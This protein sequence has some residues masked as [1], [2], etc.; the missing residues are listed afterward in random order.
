MK[1]TTVRGSVEFASGS[2]SGDPYLVAFINSYVESGI[3]TGCNYWGAV[4][5]GLGSDWQAYMTI[6]GAL[7]GLTGQEPVVEGVPENPDGYQ[8]EGAFD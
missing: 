7:T 2:L 8:E 1:F 3:P 5:P 6:C 4:E